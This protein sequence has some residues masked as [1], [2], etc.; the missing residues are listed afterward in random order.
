MG[1]LGRPPGRCRRRRVHLPAAAALD[2]GPGAVRIGGQA[3]SAA[4]DG[5]VSGRFPRSRGGHTDGGGGSWN[6]VT[7]RR[8]Q[9]RRARARASARPGG[10]GR[11]WPAALAA[12]LVAGVSAW[13]I[14]EAARVLRARR[15][16]DDR[17]GPE[18]D[19]PDVRDAEC[20]V[21]KNALL[22]FGSL[23]G[24]LGMALGVG[25]GLA[26]RPPRPAGRA[27]A[28]GLILGGSPGGHRRGRAADGPPYPERPPGRPHPAVPRP[29]GALGAARGRG[30]AG[31]RA[32][33]GAAAPGSL[34]RL[35]AAPGDPA[36]DGRLRVD[37]RNRL[38]ARQD[39]QHL[40]ADLADALIA[41]LCVT[42]GRRRG[43][44]WE[45]GPRR[46]TPPRIP[47]RR[48][49]SRGGSREFAHPDIGS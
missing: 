10:A 7:V 19:E 48:D 36:G 14:G 6:R 49:L 20:G 4:M 41:R 21:V 16:R 25:G 40:L 24:V 44:R 45:S 5:D 8:G 43:R 26:R 11:P 31:L 9:D 37:R 1:R 35:S 12:G 29:L 42:L 13:L 22:V 28:V 27:A 46:N 3:H 30:R 23:G 18:G 34:A 15:G 39:R 33:G 32:G 47:H 2:G 38:P 17:H